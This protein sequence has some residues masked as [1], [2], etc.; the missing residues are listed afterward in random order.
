MDVT[1]LASAATGI[2]EQKHTFRPD[3]RCSEFAS[4][5]CQKCV[6]GEKCAK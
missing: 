1:A 5:S 4:Q 3:N 6:F 2:N